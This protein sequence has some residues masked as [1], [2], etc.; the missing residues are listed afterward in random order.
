MDPGENVEGQKLHLKAW[1]NYPFVNKCGHHDIY[2]INY[3][4]PRMSY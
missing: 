4:N 1:L 3:D 2:S